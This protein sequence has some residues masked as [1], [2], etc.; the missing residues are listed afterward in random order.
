M[1]PGTAI[2]DPKFGGCMICVCIIYIYEL[3]T[4][5]IK[6]SGIAVFVQE[7]KQGSAPPVKRGA[8]TGCP[9]AK[10]LLSSLKQRL[11]SEAQ[12]GFL[13]S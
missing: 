12:P 3:C 2:P 8:C 9:R 1:R 7:N 11:R 4:P 6:G 13:Q 5:R 10:T